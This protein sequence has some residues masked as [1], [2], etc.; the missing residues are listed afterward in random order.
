MKFA[1]A[2]FIAIRNRDDNEPLDPMIYMITATLGFVALENAL[3]IAGPLLERD[4]VGGIITGNFRF[5]GASLL[6]IVA[7]SVIGSALAL[8]FY[9][10]RKEKVAWGIF[11]FM[12][13]VLVHTA[14]N[15]SIIR[16]NNMGTFLTFG[17][18]WAGVAILIL[19]FEKVKT[20]VPESKRKPK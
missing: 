6:H 3:F 4:I 18:V 15:L 20:V 17:T 2:Y 19:M 11:A 9:K 5:I 14:F 12:L 7:S 13:A 10:S 1:A 16:Q 8:T